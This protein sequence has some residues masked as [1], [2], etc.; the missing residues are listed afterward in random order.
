MTNITIL[1]KYS[2][3]GASSRYRYFLYIHN[4]LKEDVNI[5]IDS[6][7]DTSYLNNF[8]NKRKK[9]KFKIF[10]S[11]VKRFFESKG[12]ERFTIY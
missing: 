2:S 5:E 3:Q 1:T 8:Y 4:L 7:V 10:I 11:Y 6:Y 12:S 9:N